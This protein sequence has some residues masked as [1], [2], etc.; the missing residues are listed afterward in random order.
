MILLGFDYLSL[1]ADR[2]FFVGV[3]LIIMLLFAVFTE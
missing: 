1:N 3:I 2:W